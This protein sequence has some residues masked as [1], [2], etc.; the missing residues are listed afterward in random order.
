[1]W[2]VAVREETHQPRIL[3][4]GIHV[5]HSAWDRAEPEQCSE[6]LSV[7]DSGHLG[8]EQ[9]SAPLSKEIFGNEHGRNP[10]I[11]YF[12][13]EDE[14]EDR[15]RPRGVL[16]ASVDPLQADAWDEEERS[17]CMCV[18][19]Y[20]YIYIYTYIERER[21]TT[22]L[23]LF[24]LLCFAVLPSFPFRPPPP[25]LGPEGREDFRV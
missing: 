19:V 17:R 4:A 22:S 5:L 6:R 12:R 1:M 8:S 20:I 11:F 23:S 10:P 3:A 14:V 18:Y 16:V 15:H 9:G 25:L 24:A 13:T 21:D 2:T 7:V